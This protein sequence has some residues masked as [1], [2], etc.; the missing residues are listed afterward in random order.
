[1]FSSNLLVFLVPK[2]FKLRTFFQGT[3]KTTNLLSL[4]KVCL[5]DGPSFVQMG[6]DGLI[7]KRIALSCSLVAV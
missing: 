6:H 7:R 2:N 1:M 4:I 3:D 5:S